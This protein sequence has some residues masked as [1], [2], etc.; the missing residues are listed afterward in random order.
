MPKV[1]VLTNDFPPRPGGIQFFVHALALRLPPGNVTVYAPAQ[2]GASEF[3]AEP[4]SYTH[5][6]LPTKA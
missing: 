5:L 4:V 3:D 6:T 2:A 1:L